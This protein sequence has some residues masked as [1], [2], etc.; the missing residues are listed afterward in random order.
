MIL[1][2]QS[3]L[4]TLLMRPAKSFHNA[5]FNYKCQHDVERHLKPKN[6][7]MID[8]RLKSSYENS[9]HLLYKEF[10]IVALFMAIMHCLCLPTKAPE[11]RHFLSMD[12]KV[13]TCQKFLLSWLFQ[14]SDSKQKSASLGSKSQIQ[15]Y[16]VILCTNVI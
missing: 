5:L 3:H 10:M 2:M 7:R 6:W 1:C 12:K 8:H 9:H 13:V 16:F 11:S 14:V 15:K 4:F